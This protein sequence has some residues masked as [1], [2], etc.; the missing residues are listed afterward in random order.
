M[1]PLHPASVEFIEQISLISE[2]AGIPRIGGRILGLLVV[3]EDALSAEDLASLLQISRASVSTNTRLLESHGV[4]RRVS[5]LGDRRVLFEIDPSYPDRL[6][7][8]SLEE[9]RALRAIST[10]TRL[11]LPAESVRAR[12][13]LR[14][15]EAFTELSVETTERMLQA[16]RD[17]QTWASHREP[18]R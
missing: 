8:R 12:A 2:S 3:E 14:R 15:I 13:V 1:K 16:W 4:I 11:K 17:Q 18:S 10:A 9:Q 5:H 6:I 7:E